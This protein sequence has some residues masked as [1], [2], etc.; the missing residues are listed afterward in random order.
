MAY[1][2][3]NYQKEGSYVE[4]QEDEL[5]VLKAVLMDDVEDL[6]MKDAWKVSF[7]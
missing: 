2:S 6:R 3:D 5:Q 1:I 4:R 7:Y